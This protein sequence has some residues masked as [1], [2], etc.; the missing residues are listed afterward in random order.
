MRKEEEEKTRG[1]ES[2]GRKKQV[3]WEKIETGKH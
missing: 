2:D 3:N 1:E